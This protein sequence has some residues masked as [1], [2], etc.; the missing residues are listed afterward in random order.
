ME[1]AEL[2]SPGRRIA[3][4]VLDALLGG[5]FLAP[6]LIGMRATG[7]WSGNN[8]DTA[9]FYAW[10][11][12]AWILYFALIVY[13]EGERGATPAK[14]LLRMRVVDAELGG[15]IG[16]RRDLGRRLMFW[17]DAIALYLG[18]LWMFW[19]PRHQAWHDKV[20]HSLVIRAAVGPSG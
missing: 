6:F 13:L 9:S 20:A 15:V 1:H 11:A 10:G 8:F 17:I 19:D 3:A 16:W 2:A 5:L 18:F 4:Y 12:P 7:D 14:W